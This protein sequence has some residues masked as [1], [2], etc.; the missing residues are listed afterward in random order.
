VPDRPP[1]NRD[2]SS[3]R[4]QTVRHGERFRPNRGPRA[5]ATLY[6]QKDDHDAQHNQH[7]GHESASCGSGNMAWHARSFPYTV[8]CPRIPGNAQDGTRVRAGDKRRL[9]TAR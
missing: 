2:G 8:E 7:A 1:K 6:R 9:Q 4:R 3:R 5:L